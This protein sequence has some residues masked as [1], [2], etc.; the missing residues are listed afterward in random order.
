[1]QIF[2]GKKRRS[3]KNCCT[4]GWGIF[5]ENEADA[6][7]VS[8]HAGGHVFRQTDRHKDKYTQGRS[9]TNATKKLCLR[10][11]NYHRNGESLADKVATKKIRFKRPHPSYTRQIM[12]RHRHGSE[13]FSPRNQIFEQSQQIESATSKSCCQSNTAGHFY[14]HKYQLP[15]DPS[16]ELTSMKS[17]CVVWDRKCNFVGG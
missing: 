4:L 11:N 15:R 10:F 13:Q 14:F 5:I 1:M 8:Y 17:F 2:W 3:T 7:H 6:W 16:V 12:C 9:G